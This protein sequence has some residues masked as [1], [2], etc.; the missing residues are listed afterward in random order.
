[1]GGLGV[2]FSMLFMH[3]SACEIFERPFLYNLSRVNVLFWIGH[4]SHPCSLGL[5]DFIFIHY[6]QVSSPTNTR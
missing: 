6:F 4:Q 2:T 1:M 5:S 3:F